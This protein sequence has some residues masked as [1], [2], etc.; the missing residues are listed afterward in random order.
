MTKLVSIFS[1]GHRDVYNG[2]RPV[3][4]GWM[5]TA[6][7]GRFATGHSIDAATARSTALGK[8]VYF[9]NIDGFCDRPSRIAHL[10]TYWTPIAQKAGFKSWEAMYDAYRAKVN[11]FAATCTIEIVELVEG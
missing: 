9:G 5:I 3:K 11:A 2:K 1:N 8:A 7:N 4:A 10:R 6:P